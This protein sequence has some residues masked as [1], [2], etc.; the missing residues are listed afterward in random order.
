MKLKQLRKNKKLT[1]QQ[2]ADI[3]KVNQQTIARWE[4]SITEPSIA[5]LK[6]LAAF[7]KITIDDLLQKENTMKHIDTDPYSVTTRKNGCEVW[8]TNENWNLFIGEL[9]NELRYP[10]QT[11]DVDNKTIADVMRK[12]QIICNALNEN[13]MEQM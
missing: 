9:T 12:A 8:V 1:Q 10:D 11:T 2:L 13:Q 6:Q 4:G 3:F 7:F 5:Q